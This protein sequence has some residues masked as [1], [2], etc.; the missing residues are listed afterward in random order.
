MQHENNVYDLTIMWYYLWAHISYHL[1]RWFPRNNRR[2]IFAV[3]MFLSKCLLAPQLYVLAHKHT[4]RWC[5]QPL[6]ELLIVSLVFTFILIGFTFLFILMIPV[7][8]ELKVAFHIF[9]LICFVEGLVLIGYVSKA[10]PCV[11]FFVLM[12]PFWIINK[13]KR[14][15]VLDVRNRSGL[16]YEPVKCCSCLWH[17]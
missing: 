6:F 7:P 13:A 15:S 11:I 1:V 3:L 2:K 9:G 17:I 16:C 4:S 12:L 14:D 10:E 8:R 5:A